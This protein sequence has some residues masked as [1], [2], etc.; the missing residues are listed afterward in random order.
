MKILIAIV[1]GIPFLYGVYQILRNEAIY[2]IRTKWNIEDDRRWY[3]YSYDYMHSPSKQN[4][5][6]LKWPRESNFY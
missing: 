4:W 5:Y 1:F 2:Q 6:G 3:K